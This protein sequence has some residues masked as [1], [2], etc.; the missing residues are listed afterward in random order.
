M[1]VFVVVGP[2][3]EMVS[4]FS[5]SVAPLP[6]PDLTFLSVFLVVTVAAGEAA[7]VLDSGK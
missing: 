5:I 7:A 2:V 4:A 1:A 3:V 6:E